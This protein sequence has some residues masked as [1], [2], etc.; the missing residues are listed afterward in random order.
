MSVLHFE[1][2]PRGRFILAFVLYIL[3][4][5]AGRKPVVM[6]ERLVFR[7]GLEDL[8]AKYPGAWESPSSIKCSNLTQVIRLD[9]FRA[10]I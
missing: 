8:L 9:S 7:K 2:Y 3:F 6:I 1:I 5:D 10:Y 4:G